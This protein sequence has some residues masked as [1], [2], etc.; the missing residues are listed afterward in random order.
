[1][2][3]Q[4]AEP[5]ERAEP[6]P[7]FLRFTTWVDSLLPRTGPLGFIGRASEPTLIGFL[8]LSGSGFF[9]DMGFLY[10]FKGV[11]GIPFP[12]AVSLGY[13]LASLYNFVMNKVLNFHA[14]GHVASQSTKWVVTATSNYLLWIL[15]LAWLLEHL[16]L[17]FMLARLSVTV[18]ETTWLYTLTRFWV[19]RGVR[20]PASSRV[21]D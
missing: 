9:V 5:I 20:P 13:G 17:Y 4:T 7:W 3:V 6:A 8:L 10:L 21:R 19:F 1:M 12:I 15:G 18:I 11:L 14:H 2:A 16:G